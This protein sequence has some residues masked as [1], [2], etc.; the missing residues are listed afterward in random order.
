M[1]GG[2]EG[3]RR[4]EMKEERPTL[5]SGCYTVTT[6]GAGTVAAV[7][8]RDKRLAFRTERRQKGRKG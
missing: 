2:G 1:G 6:E 5:C 8:P 7:S 3:D 4:P